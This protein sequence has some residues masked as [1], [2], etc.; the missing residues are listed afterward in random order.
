MKGL[1]SPSPPGLHDVHLYPPLP[2][3]GEPPHIARFLLYLARTL[4]T[5]HPNFN[6]LAHQSLPWSL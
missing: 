5:T 3:L 4:K 1:R 6:H 2:F